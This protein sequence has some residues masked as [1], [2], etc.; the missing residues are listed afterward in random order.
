MTKKEKSRG[1]FFYKDK[2]GKKRDKDLHEPILAGEHKNAD[3]IGKEAARR[4]GLT[5]K[6]IGALYGGE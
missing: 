3:A 4:A 2:S 6:E 5:E 1:E